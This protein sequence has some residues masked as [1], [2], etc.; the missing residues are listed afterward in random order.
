MNRFPRVLA[1]CKMPARVD[2]RT[3]LRVWMGKMPPVEALSCI[4]GMIDR[5][6]NFPRF[7]RL[8]YDEGIRLLKSI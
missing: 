8:L 2:E 6:K 3:F 4:R 7:K 5:S 1:D